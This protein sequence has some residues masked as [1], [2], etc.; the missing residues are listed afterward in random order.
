[1]ESRGPAAATGLGLSLQRLFVCT[2]GKEVEGGGAGAGGGGEEEG[3]SGEKAASHGTVS[4]ST[5]F[6]CRNERSIDLF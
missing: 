3:T 4:T 1:M 2:T 5:A 6:D